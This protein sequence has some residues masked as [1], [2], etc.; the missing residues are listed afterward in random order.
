M[1]LILWAANDERLEKKLPLYVSLL[2][3]FYLMF[4]T[5][6]H[7]HEPEP[8]PHLRVGGVGEASWPG[9]WLYFV[10]PIAATLLAAELYR[11]LLA[12]P[13]GR[14]VLPSTSRTEM[15]QENYPLCPK[16]SR[17]RSCPTPP[18]SPTW[19]RRPSRTSPT[20]FPPGS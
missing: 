4:A 7:R 5:P 8:C 6:V 20:T 1:M 17:A 14:Q 11:R 10:A 13:A 3:A 2:I 15:S 19:T 16:S 18:S 12:R 9:L